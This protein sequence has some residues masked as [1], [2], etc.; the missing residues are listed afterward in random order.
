[1]VS[2]QASEKCGAGEAGAS[3][4]QQGDLI[5]ALAEA[6]DQNG[7]WKEKYDMCLGAIAASSI[8][9]EKWKSAEAAVAG[10]ACN[11]DGGGLVESIQDVAF[12]HSQLP[13]IDSWAEK[14]D[15]FSR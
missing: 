9:D 6:I 7:A 5:T 13:G 3:S 11:E 14:M 15:G 4:W 1:M 10:L 12:L 2:G 8:H